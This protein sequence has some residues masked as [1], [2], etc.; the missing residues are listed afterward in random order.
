[1]AAHAKMLLVLR[2][3]MA[4]LSSVGAR[5]GADNFT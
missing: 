1:M 3:R 4:T 2:R 5:M